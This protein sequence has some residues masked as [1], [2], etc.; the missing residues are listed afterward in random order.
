MN[1]NAFLE[2]NEADKLTR[3]QK[4]CDHKWSEIEWDKKKYGTHKS[5]QFLAQCLDCDLE[6]VLK[7]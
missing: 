4:S 1:F 7:E 6:K 3:E 2:L 5:G